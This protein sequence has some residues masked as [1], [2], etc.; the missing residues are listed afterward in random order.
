DEHGGF[1]DHVAPPPTVPPGDAQADGIVNKHQFAFDQLGPRVPALIISPLIPKNLVDH[2]VYDHTS[3]LATVERLL[4]V[5]PRTE[6][7]RNANSLHTLTSLPAPRADT[8]AELTTPAGYHA[9]PRRRRAASAVSRPDR[10]I[11]EGQGAGF[12]YAAYAQDIEVSPPA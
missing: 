10:S 5:E 11:D 6:R 3:V 9:P 2:R 8:P 12:V 7:D 1:Y 4:G